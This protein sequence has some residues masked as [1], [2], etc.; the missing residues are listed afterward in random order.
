MCLITLSHVYLLL[1]SS[2]FVFLYEEV[3]IVDTGF[4]SLEHT[5]FFFG[6]DIS[7]AR[8]LILFDSKP[9]TGSRQ[10]DIPSAPTVPLYL[11]VCLTCRLM[12]I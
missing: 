11:V 7:V 8:Y 9:I 3:Y 2:K 1:S 6:S 10:S 12:I 4:F 5:F